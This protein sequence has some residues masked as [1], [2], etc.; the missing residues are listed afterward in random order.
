MVQNLFNDEVKFEL[1]FRPWYLLV[2][3]SSNL[4]YFYE[5]MTYVES[6]AM[7]VTSDPCNGGRSHLPVPLTNLALAAYLC[8]V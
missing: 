2:D 1:S 8:V 6:T 5:A 4:E 7:V 3:C